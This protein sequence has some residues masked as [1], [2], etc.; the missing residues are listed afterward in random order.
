MT[1]QLLEHGGEKLLVSYGSVTGKHQLR[2]TSLGA[3][4]N[5]KH[6]LLNYRVNAY[7]QALTLV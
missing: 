3:S 5:W 6:P 1:E 7:Y 2:G 4:V